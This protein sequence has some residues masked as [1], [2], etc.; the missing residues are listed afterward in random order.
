[1]QTTTDRRASTEPQCFW[2]T[3]PTVGQFTAK[4]ALSS[5]HALTD[6]PAYGI[7]VHLA[8]ARQVSTF[9]CAPHGSPGGAGHQS[10]GPTPQGK[11]EC[12]LDATEDGADG[13]GWTSTLDD[14]PCV[15]DGDRSRAQA[16]APTRQVTTRAIAGRLDRLSMT[17]R[18]YPPGG[19]A[20]DS[21]RR[22][23]T[24]LIERADGHLHLVRERSEG[25]DV[26][27]FRA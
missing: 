24:R 11:S 4:P 19:P 18:G 17:A 12:A 10:E 6:S 2:E 16:P 3:Q 26:G 27:C 5:K 22:A 13:A 8:S 9:L 20:R 21:H 25:D 7:P 15:G 23:K 14:G 1:M